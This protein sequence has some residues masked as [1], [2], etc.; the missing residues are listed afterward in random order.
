MQRRRFRCSSK[1]EVSR[2]LGQTLA[3]MESGGRWSVEQDGGVVV[4]GVERLCDEFT[5]G[6]WRWRR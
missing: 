6:P 4:V 1:A 3:G 5:A 2:L